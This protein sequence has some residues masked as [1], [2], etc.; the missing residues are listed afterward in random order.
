MAILH[1]D[2]FRE[3][4]AERSGTGVS[5]YMPTHPHGRQQQQDAIR[6][7]NLVNRASEQLQDRGLRRPEAEQMLAPAAALRQDDDVW[8]HRSDGLACFCGD[9]FFRAYRVPLQLEEQLFINDRFHIRPLLPLLHADARFF[10]LA[11]SQESARLFEAT[12]ESIQELELPGLAPVEVDGT[13]QA[14][15]YHSHQAPSQGRGATAQAIYHGH[16]GPGDREKTDILQ[17]FHRVDRAVRDELRDEQAPMALACVGYLAPIYQSANNYKNLLKVK[18]PGSPDR[19]SHDE[20]RSHAWQLLEPHLR[21]SQQQAIDKFERERGNS[22]TSEDLR[23]IVLS[24][25]RGRV[26]ALFIDNEA[27]QWGRVEPALEA[28]HLCADAAEADEELFDYAATHTLASG[29]EVFALD[30][31]PFTT[32]QVAA[33]YRY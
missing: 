4:I 15:Q 17:F 27:Q 13:E 12:R 25:H 32:S 9:D 14:L 7:K 24:A 33:T 8:S 6:L 2:D 30:D 22:R 26:E 5:I 16:G 10:I 11:I 18:V 20:M 1:R 29:G 31:L 3:L 28:V 21:K 19:W 23:E